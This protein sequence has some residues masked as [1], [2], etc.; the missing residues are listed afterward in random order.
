MKADE[1][2]GMDKQIREIKRYLRPRI[3]SGELMYLNLMIGFICVSSA[4]S[5]FVHNIKIYLETKVFNVTTTLPFSAFLLFCI[6]LCCTEGIYKSIKFSIQ[7]GKWKKTGQMSDILR[8]FECAKPMHNGRVMMGKEYAFGK[9]CSAAIAYADID[10][11]YKYVHTINFIR[12]QRT[13]RVKMTNGK[14]CNLCYLRVFKIDT[15]EE[16]AIILTILDRNPSV[17]LGTD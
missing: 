13:I 3:F 17:E 14:E 8:D 1:E 6:F 9:N 7:L 5:F 4:I 11:V 2:K 15:E 10:R 12:D 16:K